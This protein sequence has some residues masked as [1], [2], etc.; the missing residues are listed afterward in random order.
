MFL[1]YTLIT[2]L[3]C[4]VLYE[5]QAD[6]YDR[7]CSPENLARLNDFDLQTVSECCGKAAEESSP[8]AADG[9]F[10]RDCCGQTPRRHRHRDSD[11]NSAIARG[12]N[13]HRRFKLVPPPPPPPTKVHGDTII[14][15]GVCCSLYQAISL[16]K[17]KFT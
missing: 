15:V 2:V 7:C 13:K 8:D 14:L 16:F 1:V 3:Q 17:T 12:T 4:F 5:V 6:S 10:F 9:E 11:P